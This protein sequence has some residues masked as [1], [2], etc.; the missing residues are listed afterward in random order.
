MKILYFDYWTKGL[1]HNILPLDGLLREEGFERILVHV[2]SW[3]DH[4]VKQEEIICGL[5]CRDIGYYGGNLR[6]M[7]IEE[8]PDAVYV[9]NVG[10]TLDRLVNRVCRNLGIKTGH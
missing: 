4:S 5:L 7:L 6:K 2:G 8:S 10:G 1:P 3:R 9:L